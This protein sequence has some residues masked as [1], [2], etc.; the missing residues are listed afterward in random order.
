MICPHLK[1]SIRQTA[2]GNEVS[3]PIHKKRLG[4][5]NLLDSGGIPSF[6][7]VAQLVEVPH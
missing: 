6:G 3:Y 4:P 1:A 7:I 2:D 5:T